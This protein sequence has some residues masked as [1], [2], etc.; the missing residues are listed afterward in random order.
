MLRIYCK[1]VKIGRQHYKC[2]LCRDVLYGFLIK[3]VLSCFFIFMSN[4]DQSR[5]PAIFKLFLSDS[6]LISFHSTSL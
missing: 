6:K 3:E 1:R 5:G 2:Q 4:R